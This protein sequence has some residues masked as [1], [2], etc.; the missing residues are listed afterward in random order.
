ME[1]GSR[2]TTQLTGKILCRTLPSPYARGS[3]ANLP[4]LRLHPR[5][6]EV[7]DRDGDPTSRGNKPKREGPVPGPRP[8]RREERSSGR[9]ESPA[10]L[11]LPPR[12]AQEPHGAG[13]RPR[14]RPPLVS[15]GAERAQRGTQASGSVRCDQGAVSS[16][17]SP[18]RPCTH[19]PSGSSQRPHNGAPAQATRPRA[20]LAPSE[21]TRA[22][23]GVASSRPSVHRA[24]GPGSARPASRTHRP[25]VL[26]EQ[27]GGGHN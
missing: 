3:H 27:S 18:H 16:V 22:A 21:R 15:W 9:A 4:G 12:A 6:L 1:P 14:K 20:V 23:L 5:R 17:S 13:C 11:G 26:G 19:P 8:R 7:L 10:L 25:R 24:G 2:A